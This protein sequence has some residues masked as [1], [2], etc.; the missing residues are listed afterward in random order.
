MPIKMIISLLIVDSW[1]ERKREA[2]RQKRKLPSRIKIL[3]LSNFYVS[4]LDIQS[5]H[6]L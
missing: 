2:D 3:S 1:G 5:H 6:E 4:L